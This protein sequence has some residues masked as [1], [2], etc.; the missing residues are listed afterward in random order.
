MLYFI[1]VLFVQKRVHS[2]GYIVAQ[3]IYF[4]VRI[5]CLGTNLGK[6]C[7]RHSMIDK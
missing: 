5:Y 6:F 7:L 4:T 3:N 2:T 1:T